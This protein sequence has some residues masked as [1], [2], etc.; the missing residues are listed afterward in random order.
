ME[1]KIKNFNVMWFTEKSNFRLGEWGEGGGG[2]KNQYIVE[3]AYIMGPGGGT[4][5]HT[6][7]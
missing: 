7:H 1:L 2:L 3:M 5:M 6:M 4:P